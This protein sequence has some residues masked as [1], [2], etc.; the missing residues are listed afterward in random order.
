M[1]LVVVGYWWVSYRKVAT[2]IAKKQREATFYGAIQANDAPTVAA[3]LDREMGPNFVNTEPEDYLAPL[4]HALYYRAD[5]VVR[6]LLERGA[7]PNYRGNQYSEPNLLR[8]VR[9]VSSS[10]QA[11]NVTRNV[12]ALL[13]KGARVNDTNASGYSPLMEVAWRE[14]ADLAK[15]LLDH[16]VAPNL[17]SREYL[18]SIQYGSVTALSLAVER[19]NRRIVRLLL[20]YGA[21]PTHKNPNGQTLIQAAK[22]DKVIIAQLK[23]ARRKKP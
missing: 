13:A 8:A 14:R 7:D 12:R 1:L 17:I 16:G 4:P 3:M 10:E 9:N 23:Q 18:S 6:L 2:L 5:A 19:R 21:D 22:G 20:A 15:I 11:D